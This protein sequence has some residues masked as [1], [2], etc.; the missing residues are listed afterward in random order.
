MT[1]TRRFGDEGVLGGLAEAA[2]AAAPP[3]IFDSIC[4][5]YRS[6]SQLEVF[7][8]RIAKSRTATAPAQS[9]TMDALRRWN[10]LSAEVEY[11]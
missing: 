6:P 4:K 10:Y 5:E 8:H 9:N 11:L 1:A 7:F 2:W 3:P